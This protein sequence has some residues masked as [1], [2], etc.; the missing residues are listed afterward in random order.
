[1]RKGSMTVTMSLVLLVFLSLIVACLRSARIAAARVA[2]A[3]GAEQGLYSLFG[4]YDRELFER[5]GLLFFDLGNGT[6]EP[7]FGAVMELLEEDI[8]CILQPNRGKILAPGNDIL[9]V[10]FS[11]GN[12]LGYQLATDAGGSAFRRQA[13]EVMKKNL[14]VAG[15]RALRERLDEESSLEKKLREDREGFTEERAAEYYA[16][17]VAAGLAEETDG[18]TKPEIPENFE[19]PMEILE[20]VKKLGY[21][22]MAVPDLR[23][24]STK[25]TEKSSLPSARELRQGMGLIEKADAG[26]DDKLLLQEYL[27]QFFPSYTDRDK[28][29]ALRYQVEYAI[30]KKDSDA[31]NLKV[32]IR[33]LLLSREAS[34]FLFLMTNN[35]RRASADSAATI[36]SWVMLMPEAKPLISFLIKLAWAYGESIMDVRRLLAGG[37]VPLWKTEASWQLNLG[38][39]G[40]ALLGFDTADVSLDRHGLDYEEYLRLLLLPK[41]ADELTRSLM[42]LVEMS[43]RAKEGREGFRLDNCLDSIEVELRAEVAGRE[44]TV[45]RRYGYEE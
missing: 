4:R 26:F 43:I 27:L 31:A 7:D 10:S 41:G 28:G 24:L 15:I 33:E 42:D 11:G 18:E 34:N 1:M 29:N 16:E 22:G 36:A 32:V 17:D 37:R 40:A 14:G 44:L 9:G 45:T 30:G 35:S 8:S 21:L 6:A 38:S 19:N 2:F 23:T 13:C 5:Y 25:E 3:S 20:S 12:I 39:V